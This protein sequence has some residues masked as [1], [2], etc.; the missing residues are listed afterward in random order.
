MTHHNSTHSF[1]KFLFFFFF[2]LIF[3]AA[4]QAVLLSSLDIKLKRTK[5]TLSSLNSSY[6]SILKLKESMLQG[7]H[8][9]Q[10][11]LNSCLNSESDLS[12]KLNQTK[13]RLQSCEER[14]KIVNGSFNDLMQEYNNVT[15]V[16]KLL[17]KSVNKTIQKINNFYSQLNKTTEWFRMNSD[18]DHFQNLK[19]WLGHYLNNYCVRTGKVTEIDTACIAYFVNQEQFHIGYFSNNSTLKFQSLPEFYRRKGGDCKGFSMFYKAEWNE[20]LDYL[21]KRKINLSNVVIKSFVEGDGNTAIGF[22]TSWILTHAEAKKI[23]GYVYPSVV[24]GLFKDYGTD[25]GHC[26]IALSKKPVSNLE[27]I[28]NSI[29]IEPQSGEFLGKFGEVASLE[30]Q[31]SDDTIWLIITDNTLFQY[32]T[33]WRSLY[34]LSSELL[35]LKSILELFASGQRNVSMSIVNSILNS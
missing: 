11:R 15:E 21:N 22:S 31:R 23:D 10:D 19:L 29:L 13:S 7:N 26:V 4:Y 33:S 16:N 32:D 35:N 14:F 27:D 20:I 18:I 2:F 9:L 17:Q 8:D 28:E 6:S 24:C 1:N 30:P 12:S 34:D 5:Q 25:F 3:V